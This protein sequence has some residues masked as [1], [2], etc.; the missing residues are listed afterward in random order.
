MSDRLNYYF[1]QKVTE[2]ELDE[3]FA[4]L[5]TAD[6]AL[7]TDNTMSG[8]VTGLSVVQR[9]AGANLSVDVSAGT[10]YD[11]DGARI[12]ITGTQNVDVSVDES[13]VTTTVGGVGNAKWL[14]LFL[15]FKR[16][17]T[18]PRTDGNSVTVYFSEAESFEFVVRQGIEGASPSPVALDSSAIL[19]A[20]IERVF[21]DT[22]ITSGAIFV[23]ARR[24]DIFVR[25]GTPY[26]ARLG[27]AKAVMHDVYDSLNIERAYGDAQDA[28]LAAALAAHLA[29]ATAAHAATAISSVGGGSGFADSSTLVAT[30]VGAA[31]DEIVGTLGAI[32]G[33]GKVGATGIVISYMFGS[34]TGTVQ[35]QLDA[36]KGYLD[37]G[38]RGGF[39]DA[40][41]NASSPVTLTSERRIEIDTSGGAVTLN[42]PAAGSNYGVTYW[43]KDVK[44]TFGTANCTLVP[45][46]A[47]KIDGVNVS[48]ALAADW[49]AYEIYSNGTDWFLV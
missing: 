44:G 40:Y 34:S 10:A 31:L 27:T 3:G 20:D 17:L 36:I 9:G 41:N 13:T 16:N 42:L 21:G 45:N 29:D 47:D 43:I 11:K 48:R 19:L 25:T 33:G 18:D 28:A 22:T 24:E 38:P 26:N 39:V 15:R 8:I 6:R 35:A 12:H 37:F 49:G 5:E 2:A 7:V 30:D 46:G 4:L 23:S 14:S 1:R 32:T